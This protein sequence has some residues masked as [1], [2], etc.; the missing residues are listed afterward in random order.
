MGVLHAWLSG[1]LAS[2]HLAIIYEV[3]S[4]LY[5]NYKRLRSLYCSRCSI[6]QAAVQ[7]STLHYLASWHY[8]LFWK[9]AV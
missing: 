5:P 6:C 4:Y 8:Q 7:Y 9:Y 2:V 1:Y 3:T